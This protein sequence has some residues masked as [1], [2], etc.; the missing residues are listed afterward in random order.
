VHR[1]GQIFSPS[2]KLRRED[3]LLAT[4]WIAVED[5]AAR[6]GRRASIS[7][8]QSACAQSCTVS[9]SVGLLLPRLYS[10]GKGSGRNSTMS[11]RPVRWSLSDRSHIPRTV[12]RSPRRLSPGRSARSCSRPPFGGAHVL[13]PDLLQ[14]NQR[15]LPRTE[16]QVLQSAERQR[17]VVFRNGKPAM[18]DSHFS[19]IRSRESPR[20]ISPIQWRYGVTTVAIFIHFE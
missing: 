10:T 17:V 5:S 19:S 7:S 1:G 4:A 15:P 9:Q 16:G 20:E 2:A 8:R 11:A 14:M 6:N 3:Y 18:R 12:R 13:H